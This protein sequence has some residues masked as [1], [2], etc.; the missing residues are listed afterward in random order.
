RPRRA[1]DDARVPEH[2]QPVLRAQ[3]VAGGVRVAG[4][5]PGRRQQRRQAS[6]GAAAAARTTTTTSASPPPPHRGQP[7]ESE[8][9]GGGG[10]GGRRQRRERGGRRGGR[11]EGAE[12]GDPSVAERQVP[13]DA[14][15]RRARLLLCSQGADLPRPLHAAP[16]DLPRCNSSPLSLSL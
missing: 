13:P 10:G 11:R 15:A 1:R 9:R 16:H 6:R 12:G 8:G 5:R 7:K 3:D 2:V 14:V 4:A